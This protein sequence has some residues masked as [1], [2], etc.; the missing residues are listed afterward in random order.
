VEQGLT[1]QEA[2]P[3]DPEVLLQPLIFQ[4]VLVAVVAVVVVLD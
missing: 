3:V 2:F 1:V 4:V